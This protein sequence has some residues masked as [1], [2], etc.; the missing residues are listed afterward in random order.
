MSYDRMESNIHALVLLNLLNLLRKRDKMPG[1]PRILSLFPK[2]FNKSYKKSTHARSS[3][4]TLTVL[5]INELFHISLDL[6]RWCTFSMCEQS[7][8]KV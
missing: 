6:R 8:C 2:L 1:K 7:L 5:L 3:I 4:Y